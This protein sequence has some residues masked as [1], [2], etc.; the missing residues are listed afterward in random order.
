MNR[1][2]ILKELKRYFEDH[3]S[4]IAVYLFGSFAKN[5]QRPHSDLDIGILFKEELGL[6]ERFEEKLAVSGELEDKLKMKIDV[7]D[8]VE[9]DPYFVHQVLTSKIL[10][11]DRCPSRRVAFEVR[12]RRTYF[13]R[14]PFYRLY[15]REALKRLEER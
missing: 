10:I 6:Y 8:L 9:T 14:Q 2:Q 5:K 13:D 15:H 3:P 1:E 12:S 4:V 7:V 11:V